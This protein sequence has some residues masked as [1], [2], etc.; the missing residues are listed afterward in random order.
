MAPVLEV[1]VVVYFPSPSP[2]QTGDEPK[3]NATN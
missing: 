1:A 2:Q 3:N